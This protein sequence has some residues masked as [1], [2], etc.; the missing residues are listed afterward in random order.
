M[1]GYNQT[2]EDKENDA[3]SIFLKYVTRE[4]SGKFSVPLLM[5]IKNEEYLGDSFR[6][7]LGRNFK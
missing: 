2:D 6:Y 5:D 7:C 4:E 3:E 1:F